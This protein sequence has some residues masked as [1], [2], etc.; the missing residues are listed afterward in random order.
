MSTWISRNFIPVFILLVLSWSSAFPVVKIGLSQSPPLLFAG[1]RTFLGGLFL[2]LPACLWGGKLR[3]SQMWPYWTWSALF[4]VIL[5]FG[6][7]TFA[8]YY[9]PS[10]LTAVL[11]YLQPILVGLF[12]R[13]WLKES[14]TWSKSL[15]LILGF[16]GV[17]FVSS[18]GVFGSLSL[19]GVLLGLGAA[20]S[21]AIGTVYFKRIQDQVSLLWLIVG[22]FIMGGLVI[23]ALSLVFES[24]TAATRNV[25]FWSS[26]LFT[27]LFGISLAWVL[28]LAL[29]QQGEVSRMSANMFA[30]PLM[31]VLMGSLFLKEPVSL[32]LLLGGG[33]ILTGI[34]LVNRRSS[35]APSR[36]AEMT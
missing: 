3:V 18:E 9:L 22:Q 4:S 25:T 11:I 36:E 7:Q 1:L 24:W 34:Y 32:F 2:V 12:A 28:Y 27:A 30:V 6:L 5:F 33:L 10:G 19:I 29:I 16:T 8:M 26:I 20:L 31:S 17:C 35:P 14:L 21:W 13:I 23:L 15:G